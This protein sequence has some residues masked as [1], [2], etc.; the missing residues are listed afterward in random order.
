MYSLCYTSHPHDYFIFLLGWP[1]IYFQSVHPV[2]CTNSL[3]CP[4]L[5][6]FSR[7]SPSCC[8]S[9]KAFPQEISPLLASASNFIQ[10]IWCFSNL[11]LK[12]WLF[13]SHSCMDEHSLIPLVYC[14]GGSGKVICLCLR[15]T[16]NELSKIELIFS[17]NCFLTSKICH[18]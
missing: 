5:W 1:S 9:I 13:W 2:S 15:E 18:W 16:P 10:M 3:L 4:K 8:C 17:T 11:Q 7:I 12:Q 6:A 14:E